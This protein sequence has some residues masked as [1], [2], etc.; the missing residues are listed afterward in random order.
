MQDPKHV[1]QA[2]KKKKKKVG[3]ATAVGTGFEGFVDWTN[4]GVSE[5]VEE[6]EAEMSGLVSSFSARIR[7]QV[8]STQGETTLIQSIWR[9]ASKA[10]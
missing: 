8:A 5:S 6:E 2:A 4:P 7:K 10:D 3:Q 1:P 9:K